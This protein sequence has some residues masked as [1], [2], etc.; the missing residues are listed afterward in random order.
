MQDLIDQRAF[1]LEQIS[2]MTDALDQY[3]KDL[4]ELNEQIVTLCQTDAS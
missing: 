4:A 1:L 2:Y 3:K